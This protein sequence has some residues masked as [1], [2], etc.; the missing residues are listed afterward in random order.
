MSAAGAASSMRLCMHTST[1][2]AVRSLRVA[3]A[4]RMIKTRKSAMTLVSCSA[5]LCFT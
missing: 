2:E 5:R 3:W 1:H 4:E